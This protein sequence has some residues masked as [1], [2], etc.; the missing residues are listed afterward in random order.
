MTASKKFNFKPLV[1]VRMQKDETSNQ[2]F[3]TSVKGGFRFPPKA[4]A[5]LDIKDYNAV[6]IF[7]DEDEDTKEVTTYIAKGHAGTIK[8]DETGAI[9]TGSRNT[10]EFEENDP[11]DGAI[12]RAS[13]DG[14]KILSV[15]S[16]AAWKTLGGSAE[17]ELCMDLVSIGVMEYPLPSGTFVE[18]EVFQLVV[19]KSRP[20]NARKK[21]EAGE[22]EENEEDVVE[23]AIVDEEFEEEEV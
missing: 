4:S 20:I 6:T 2:V 10:T 1:N 21:K 7:S 19:T 14:S 12:V 16:A 11:M 18:G 9:V 15:N 17:A 5:L 22:A 23:N 13:S 8:R 3:T